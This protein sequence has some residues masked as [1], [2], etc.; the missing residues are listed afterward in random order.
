MLDKEVQPKRLLTTESSNL[1]PE[2]A[3]EI[4]AIEAKHG[5]PSR[6]DIENT[7]NEARG[8]LNVH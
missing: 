1:R 6:A 5:R 7:I 2:D 3:L 4:A 8:T